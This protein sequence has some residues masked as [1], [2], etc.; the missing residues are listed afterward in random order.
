MPAGRPKYNFYAVSNGKEVGIFTNWTQA[1]DSVLGF[2]NAKYKG[3]ITY[4]E[5]KSAMES[6]GIR[7]FHVFDGQITLSKSDYERQVSYA[8]KNETI[9]ISENEIQHKVDALVEVIYKDEEREAT[10]VFIDGSCLRNGSNSAKAGYGVYWG[11]DHPWNGS[12]T[13]PIE[14]GATN[15]KAELRAAIKA[16]EVADAN[17]IEKLVVNSDSKYVVQG[18]TQ[19]SENWCKN[20]WKTSNGESVKNKEEWVQLLHLVN[21]SNVSI[22]WNHVPGHKGISGNEEADKLAVQ[23][24]NNQGKNLKSTEG[25]P[26]NNPPSPKVQPKV[27]VIGKILQEHQKKGTKIADTHLTSTP[28]RKPIKDNSDTPVAGCINGSCFD[29]NAAKLNDKMSSG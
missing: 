27:I 28:K 1:S 9:N 2:A 11:V 10:T 4:S 7:E 21:E 18:I 15:N 29:N 8:A 17:K 24:A 20:G 26:T 25:T 14:E 5:A 3:Y 23:G 12:Y 13:M 19:W 16:I 22:T 6:A